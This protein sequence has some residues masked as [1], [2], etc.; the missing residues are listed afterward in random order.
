MLAIIRSEKALSGWL[1]EV[2]LENMPD[3]EVILPAYE[4]P[5]GSLKR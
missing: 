2:T 5:I 4:L 3:T 1:K